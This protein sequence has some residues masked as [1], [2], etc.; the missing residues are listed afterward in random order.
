MRRAAKELLHFAWQGSACS[1]I[2]SNCI[3]QI[4]RVQKNL[5]G[6]SEGASANSRAEKEKGEH[7]DQTQGARRGSSAIDNSITP[8]L[9]QEAISE[10]GAFQA[11]NPDRDVLN[12]G[13]L[14]P[15]GRMGLELPG[16]AVNFYAP[17]TAYARMGRAGSGLAGPG[18]SPHWISSR[19]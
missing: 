3:A 4:I 14:T 18:K 5:E 13:A 8:A 2:F 16:G 1:A 10:P 11:M 9:A 12:G 15:A 6:A 7:H 17:N 19:R